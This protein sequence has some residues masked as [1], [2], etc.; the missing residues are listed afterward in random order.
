LSRKRIGIAIAVLTITFAL[1][2]LQ[3]NANLYAQPQN[4]VLPGF[5]TN[6]TTSPSQLPPTQA[7]KD[8]ALQIA[9]TS[10]LCQ[11]YNTYPSESWSCGWDTIPPDGHTVDVWY[12]FSDGSS[13]D[14]VVDLSNQ[15]IV[16]AE[17]EPSGAYP[18]VPGSWVSSNVPAVSPTTDTSMLSTPSMLTSM[19][20]IG[21]DNSLLSFPSLSLD[22]PSALSY[23]SIMQTIAPLYPGQDD[24]LALPY[25]F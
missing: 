6:T 18:Y 23:S 10:S 19:P 17:Y 15:S 14:I 24:T 1:S 2:L 7:Q 21:T 4:G 13:L 12:M 3:A 8:E 11:Q 25:Q 20:S 22:T 16:S 5:G 9:A